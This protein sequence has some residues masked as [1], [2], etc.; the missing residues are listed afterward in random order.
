MVLIQALITWLTRSAGKVLNALVGWSVIGLFGR[1]SP[2][3]QAVLSGLIL[4]AAIWPL[5]VLGVIAPRLAAFIVSFV[6][7]ARSIP[8]STLR[9]AWIV[10]MLAIPA[11]IGVALAAKAPKEAPREAMLERVARGFPLTLGLACALFMMLVL[12]PVVRLISIARRWSDEHVPLITEG[13]QMIEAADRIDAILSAHALEARGAAPPWWMRAPTSVLRALGGRTIAAVMPRDQFYWQGPELQV[14]LYPSDILVRGPKQRAS[15]THGLIAEAFA[16]GPG[17]QTFEPRA[18]EIERQIQ[19]LWRVRDAEPEA[20][21]GSRILLARLREISRDLAEADV[22]YDEWQV[23]YRQIAQLAR[24]IDAEPQLM[25]WAAK[26]DSMKAEGRA[27]APDRPLEHVSTPSLISQLVH[28]ASELLKKEVALARAEVR[29]D[30]ADAVRRVLGMAIAALFGFLG[31]A[32]L[33]AAAVLGLTNRMEPWE[34]A[35]LVAAIVFGI[36]GGL[37]AMTKAKEHPPLERTRRTLKED[38]QWA[39]ERIG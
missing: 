9:I 10:L 12:M 32:L 3:Q 25:Q 19:R 33:C 8:D 36:A 30:V 39:K 21:T 16:R 29:S 7:V 24:A 28:D 37:F 14:A 5:T 27:S 4:A 15:W 6:P 1:S 23:V 20:H 34:A 26:E 11:A 17:F 35:L 22:P 38:V 13:E 2:R 18:Q 31:V